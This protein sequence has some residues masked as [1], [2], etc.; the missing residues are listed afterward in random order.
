MI[1]GLAF[2]AALLAA[3]AAFAQSEV[4]CPPRADGWPDPVVRDEDAARGIFIAVA[5]QFQGG[6]DYSGIPVTVVESSDHRSWAVYHGDPTSSEKLGGGMH[7]V[8]DRCTGAI[9]RLRYQR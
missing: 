1:R 6:A 4:R 7:M 5:D 2:T 8:I 9:T 3:P